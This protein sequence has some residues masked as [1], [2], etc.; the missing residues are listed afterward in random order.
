MSQLFPDYRPLWETDQH[1]ELRKHA[2]EFLRKEATPH[3]ERWVAQHGVDRDFWN[4]AGDYAMHAVV[5]E[6]LVYARRFLG[7]FAS[8]GAQGVEHVLV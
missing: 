3:Q 4:K 6:E 2:A 5:Q 8:S 1:R 7:A